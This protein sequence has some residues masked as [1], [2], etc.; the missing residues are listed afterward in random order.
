MSVNGCLHNLP[1]S[2]PWFTLNDRMFVTQV[3]PLIENRHLNAATPLIHLWLTLPMPLNVK[4]LRGIYYASYKHF[5]V[6]NLLLM[7]MDFIM[8][9]IYFR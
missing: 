8:I 6:R 9:E 3:Y 2:M 1:L 7:L 5:P 4:R